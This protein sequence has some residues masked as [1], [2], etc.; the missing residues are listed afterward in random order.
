MAAQSGIMAAGLTADSEIFQFR[1]VDA[2]RVMVPRLIRCSGGGIIGFAAGD[3][4]FRVKIARAWTADGTGGTPILFSG[5]DQKKA[6][7][8]P[9]TLAPSNAGVRIATTTGLGVGTKVFDT[10]AFIE[11]DFGIS[12]TA[13]AQLGY[14]EQPLWAFVPITRPYDM[15]DA[16]LQLAQ[17]E[18][19]VITA[20]VPATGTWTFGVTIDWVE[21]T[22]ASG[23]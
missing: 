4:A 5:N 11:S 10:N 19:L 12:A 14:P 7:T 22:L 9:T 21:A 16:P 18:G 8:F 6:T 1:W 20:T 2:T 15:D 13:G 17:N 3:G 23:V